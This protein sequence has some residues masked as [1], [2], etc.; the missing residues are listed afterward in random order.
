MRKIY[1]ISLVF[2]GLIFS[3]SGKTRSKEEALQIATTFYGHHVSSSMQKSPAVKSLRLT[4]KR[5]AGLQTGDSATCFYVFNQG[6]NN[7]YVIVSADDRAI[8][9]LGY[10]DSG[11]FD[12]TNIP[13]NMKDWLLV[14]ENEIKSLSDR[15]SNA[16]GTFVK[17]L[18]P[19][20]ANAYAASITPLLGGIKWNQGAPYN[21]LCPII[22]TTTGARAVSGCVATGMAQV[23]KYHQW[24][25][26]GTGSNSYTTYTNSIPLSLDF[27]QTTF[28][29]TNMT[30]TYGTS[31][32]TA[33]NQAVATL[34]YN[35]GVAVN[36]DYAESSGASTKTMAMAL[37]TYFGYDSNLQFYSRNYFTRNEWKNLL[38]TELN[39][40]RP[41]LYS[42]YSNDGGHLFVCDGYDSN[43]LFHFNW[44]WGGSSN[45]YF[46]ISAL[47]PSEQGIGGSSG[48]YNGGQGI[49]TGL[50]KPTTS[51]VAT[52]L[53]HT[54]DTLAYSADSIA[55]T[56]T[57]S[58]TAKNMFNQGVNVFSGYIGVALYN[59]IGGFVQLLKYSTV[60]ELK[61]GYGWSNF[62]LSSLVLSPS[63]AT[64][65]YKLHYVYKTATASSWEIVRGYVGTPNYIDVKIGTTFIKFDTPT[66]VSPSLQLNSLITTGNLYQNKTGRFNVDITNNGGE[67][68]SKIHIYL[69][70][71]TSDTTYQFVSSENVNF[72]TGETRNLNFKGNISV[73]PGRYYLV[74]MYDPANNQDK[75][76]MTY[77]LGNYQFVD[78]LTTPT[79]EANLTLTSAIS[80]PNSSSVERNLA[81]L[82]ANIKNTTGYY[83]NK[84]IA[85]IFPK[86]GGSSLTYLGYQDA[87]FDANESKRITFS[88]SISLDLNQYMTVV[89]GRNLANSWVRIA[90]A[91]YSV[92]NFT[93]V[94]NALAVFNPEFG[95]DLILFPN[96]VED[97]LNVKSA[98][99]I[100]KLIVCDLLG[101]QMIILQPTSQN[102]ISIP[103]NNLNSGTYIIRLET[104]NGIKVA[105]FIKN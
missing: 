71:T 41:I 85:F 79:G 59:S 5:S 94:D 13:E 64:G 105:K 22:N 31:S 9:V 65:N 21:N 44:G 48:G 3:A 55:R 40:A 78:I 15:T 80:F 47:D 88:G 63:L 29:W 92:L 46:Q 51:S 2:I 96:P 101:K 10:T 70:S 35:C 36:M 26:K 83:D 45:G 61:V 32:T 93:L 39:A 90:P 16:S 8:P 81:T 89:Y 24:P 86:T 1:L 56:A 100:H 74:V 6:E 60:S 68:N 54:N 37:K 17:A 33:Q 95:E 62:T 23:M 27:S 75:N 49:V 12:L 73:A 30:D 82:T 18:T 43:D 52:Y 87:I 7:G 72:A 91:E 20:S 28:D 97:I 53:I 11:S 34:M 58:V 19:S 99:Q 76:A 42:G 50:Q 103:T 38:K 57:F 67:Y 98:S 69:E 84:L 102:Q 25:A 77:Q 104:E 66:T 14:Y 4:Y